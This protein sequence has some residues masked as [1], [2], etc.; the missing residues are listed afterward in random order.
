LIVVTY[1]LCSLT[2]LILW[3]LSVPFVVI[4][5]MQLTVMAQNGLSVSHA[6][7]PLINYACMDICCLH[8]AVM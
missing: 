7:V 6:D 1:I 5:F 2:A 3:V 8:L 4:I